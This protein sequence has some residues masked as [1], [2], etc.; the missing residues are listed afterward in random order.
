M[1]KNHQL[2][3]IFCI[4]GAFMLLSMQ[5]IAQPTFTPTTTLTTAT[6]F[7]EAVDCI[8][9]NA[10]MYTVG[11]RTNTNGTFDMIIARYNYSGVL[12]SS[13]TRNLSGFDEV[14]VKIKA[15]ASGN[16]YVLSSANTS[17]TS[18]DLWLVKYNSTLTFQWSQTFSGSTSSNDQAVDMV[19]SGSNVYV[20][21]NSV[22]ASSGSNVILVRYNTSGTLLNQTNFQFA[23]N[24]NDEVATGLNFDGTSVYVCGYRN[25]GTS[26]DGMILKYN[27]SLTLLFST[28]WSQFTTIS[29]NDAF[30]AIVTDGAHIYVAGYTNNT[31][32][33]IP[34]K[35]TVVARFN[36]STGALVNAFLNSAFGSATTNEEFT[37]I[38]IEGTNIYTMGK[39]EK[40]AGKFSILMHKY[41]NSLVAA[42]GW[43]RNY[44]PG[45]D[46]YIGFDLDV[47]SSGGD[48][49]VTGTAFRT[50]TSGINYTSSL[51]LYYTTGGTVIAEYATPN[52]AGCNT[53]ETTGKAGLIW[54]NLSYDIAICGGHMAWSSTIAN[55]KANRAEIWYTLIT[56]PSPPNDLPSAE[57]E[58]IASSDLDEEPVFNIFPNPA[59]TE[60][61]ISGKTMA[62]EIR[63]FDL[64]GKLV[65]SRAAG[66]NNFSIDITDLQ[67]GQYIMHLDT[68]KGHEVS[69]FIKL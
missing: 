40:S 64:T 66:S 12:L 57:Q 44:N 39:K 45:S 24:T 42:S 35:E 1:K 46:S 29:T 60:L 2:N 30:N 16:I 54:G 4:I 59:T 67:P 26:L 18:R 41:N 21:G 6:R 9:A 10:S 63:I 61:R 33:T 25:S 23:A 32:V 13:V 47:R 11:T 37:H 65:S 69:E 34:T 7:M 28:S 68:E 52:N 62:T 31:G 3:F 49:L 36:K 51:T 43:P 58:R 56:P 48:V 55:V 8:S 27:S 20:L 5:S 50:S 17:S 38:A 53:L 22:Q 14:P 19:V 15:D